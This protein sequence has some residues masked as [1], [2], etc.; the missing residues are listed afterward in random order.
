MAYN[1]LSYTSVQVEPCVEPPE[2]CLHK[3]LEWDDGNLGHCK[4]LTPEQIEVGLGG[5][6]LVYDDPL[7]CR[8]RILFRLTPPDRREQPRAATIFRL[9]IAA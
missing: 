2:S 7:E 8:Y 6:Y 5:G 9:L 4:R 3:G 1:R